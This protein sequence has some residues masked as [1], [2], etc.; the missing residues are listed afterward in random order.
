MTPVKI[1]SRRAGDDEKQRDDGSRD[2]VTFDSVRNVLST[3]NM[4][5][6]LYFGANRAFRRCRQYWRTDPRSGSAVWTS[7]AFKL[8]FKLQTLLEPA[9]IRD[10]FFNCL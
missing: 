3:R 5:D 9:Q 1:E 2:L 6:S 4:T 10:Q 8:S 7:G